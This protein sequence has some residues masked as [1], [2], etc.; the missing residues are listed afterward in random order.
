M[1]ERAPSLR[2]MRAVDRECPVLMDFWSLL[3]GPQMAASC[4][5]PR[6]P[7]AAIELASF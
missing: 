5:S 1:R 4:D 6:L 7:I 3:K 2:K